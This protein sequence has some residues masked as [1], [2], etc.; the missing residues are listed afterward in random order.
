MMAAEED[1]KGMKESLVDGDRKSNDDAECVEK[2]YR[3]TEVV[4]YEEM[5]INIGRWEEMEEDRKWEELSNEHIFKTSLFIDWDR[6]RSVHFDQRFL[7]MAEGFWSV[8]G[9]G[10]EECSEVLTTRNGR[11]LDDTSMRCIYRGIK[12]GR[13][14]GRYKYEFLMERRK[15]LEEVMEEQLKF[16][17]KDRE[18]SNTIDMS[19]GSDEEHMEC[20]GNLSTTED[21]DVEL[22]VKD[23]YRTVSGNTGNGNGSRTMRNNAEQVRRYMRNRIRCNGIVKGKGK[24][25]KKKSKRRE[26]VDDKKF[27]LTDFDGSGT[28]DGISMDGEQKWFKEACRVGQIMMDFMGERWIEVPHLRCVHLKQNSRRM[29]SVCSARV[30]RFEPNGDREETVTLCVMVEDFSKDVNR[31]NVRL[32]QRKRNGDGLETDSET[33]ESIVCSCKVERRKGELKDSNCIHRS[34]VLSNELLLKNIRDRLNSG[35]S[36][37]GEVGVD[38]QWFGSWVEL[39]GDTV[40]VGEENEEVIICT[41]LDRIDGLYLTSRGKSIARSWSCWNVFDF[42]DANFVCCIRSALGSG[43]D[44]TK[45]KCTQCKIGSRRKCRHESACIRMISAAGGVKVNENGEIH[46][47]GKSDANENDDDSYEDS[48]SEYSQSEMGSD[49]SELNVAM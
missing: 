13:K 46:E 21:V 11:N 44:V 37:T 43:V 5:A 30:K 10:T 45:I 14:A 16:I 19:N 40:T 32:K 28:K 2:F 35:L 3:Y 48:S 20:D 29:I 31:I 42:S 24:E 12:K 4:N 47:L 7:E 8:E 49:E 23:M 36:E 27:R 39:S 17:Q 33:E 25:A 41:Q 9:N 6:R 22:E 18:V 1:G 26:R 34:I 38:N 15:L